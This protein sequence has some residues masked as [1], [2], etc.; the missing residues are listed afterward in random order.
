MSVVTSG[1][2]ATDALDDV[3]GWEPRER[4]RRSDGLAG[5]TG[6]TTP[7]GPVPSWPKPTVHAL[8]GFPHHWTG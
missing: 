3:Q 1:S 2:S 4:H 6:A 7:R 8:H 5:V